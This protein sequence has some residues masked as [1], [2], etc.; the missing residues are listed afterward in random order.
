MLGEMEQGGRRGCGRGLRRRFGAAV[1]FGRL[2]CGGSGFG[3]AA[4]AEF[5]QA[6]EGPVEAAFEGGLAAPDDLEGG[7]EVL[8]VDSRL[9]LGFEFF[10][11]V[12][13]MQSDGHLLDEG[14]F[15]VGLGLP[16]G[17]E[18]VA[19]RLQ[20]FLLFLE[21]DFAGAESVFEGILAG[22]GFAFW[23]DGAGGELGIAAV[24]LKLLFGCH[25]AVTDSRVAGEERKTFCPESRDEA[26]R[27][28]R[29]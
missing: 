28:P 23:G 15:G 12:A 17:D 22:D 20:R 29:G 8:A 7:R 21:E 19:D 27:A 3:G 11:A 24:G 16:L 25:S 26:G 2:G 14:P 9:R 6:V 10:I 1:A 4:F 18:A 13:L 5:Q